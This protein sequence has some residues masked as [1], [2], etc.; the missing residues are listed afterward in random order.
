[1]KSV[2]QQNNF[3]LLIFRLLTKLS[4][5]KIFCKCGQ[6]GDSK[7]KENSSDYD[8]GKESPI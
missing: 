7:N 8:S 3:F 1:V 4:I 5:V 2:R 6:R